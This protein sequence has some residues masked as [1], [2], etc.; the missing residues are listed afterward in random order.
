MKKIISIPVLF[1][2]LYLLLSTPVFAAGLVPCSGADCTFNCFMKMFH[3]ILYNLV[4]LKIVIPLVVVTIV[5]GGFMMMFSAG[6]PKKAETGKKII[7]S[8]VVGAVIVFCGWLI[9]NL[10]FS[11]LVK[12]SALSQSPLLEGSHWYNVRISCP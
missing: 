4:L 11:V 12:P 6:D 3:D 9:V 10:L 7:T 5:W 8:A 2:A 1:S